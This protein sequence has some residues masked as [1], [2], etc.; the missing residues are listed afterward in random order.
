M[1][2]HPEVAQSPRSRGRKSPDVSGNVITPPARTDAE[3]SPEAESIRQRNAA[4]LIARGWTYQ[5]VAD[6]FTVRVDVRTIYRWVDN[7]AFWAT[8]MEEYRTMWRDL[9]P[10][11][12][13]SIYNAM[14]V[15]DAMINGSEPWDDNRYRAAVETI[16]DE[17][18]KLFAFVEAEGGQA[19]DDGPPGSVIEGQFADAS[20]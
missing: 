5:R 4:R 12:E 16:R 17:R 18:D 10:R 15:R 20:A 3:L 9:T 8:V 19:D 13:Q 7:R 1:G 14:D 11:A 6:D 2:P